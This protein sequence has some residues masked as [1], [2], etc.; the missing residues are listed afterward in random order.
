[1]LDENQFQYD[2]ICTCVLFLLLHYLG[3]F[4]P[5]F[6]VYVSSLS[7]IYVT[8]TIIT[9]VGKN[10]E[11]D[12]RFSNETIWVSDIS[13]CQ[14]HQIVKMNLISGAMHKPCTGC[15]RRVWATSFYRTELLLPS[16]YGCGWKMKTFL[17]VFLI[18][19][20][21]G[22]TP[23]ERVVKAMSFQLGCNLNVIH[24]EC[25]A[26]WRQL[27]LPP[28]PPPHC[29]ASFNICGSQ[30]RL[31]SLVKTSECSWRKDYLAFTHS[32]LS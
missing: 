1:M 17:I 11:A 25:Y 27:C 29:P 19:T 18:P 7:V 30:Q 3:N 24:L 20:Y 13:V 21:L 5:Y 26:Q 8:L 15:F 22:R 16:G 23:L 9:K 12:N 2:S 10:E 32:C 14:V 28:P 6:V 31:F 4:F